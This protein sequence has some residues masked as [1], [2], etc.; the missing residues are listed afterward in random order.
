MFLPFHQ[1]IDYVPLLRLA[2]D[3]RLRQQQNGTTLWWT[4][5]CGGGADLVIDPTLWEN[6][7]TNWGRILL[8]DR[9]DNEGLFNEQISSLFGNNSVWAARLS[10]LITA[11]LIIVIL[12][13]LL[14]YGFVVI[15]R[16]SQYR[17]KAQNCKATK[18]GGGFAQ[19]IDQQLTKHAEEKRPLRSNEEESDDYGKTSQ[20]Q[21]NYMAKSHGITKNGAIRTN[22]GEKV[23]NGLQ[24]QQQREKISVLHE[25][26]NEQHN[27]E[28]NGGKAEHGQ[29]VGMGDERLDG[30]HEHNG[31]R[32]GTL[33][34]PKNDDCTFVATPL[35]QQRRRMPTTPSATTSNNNIYCSNLSAPPLA[36]MN[37][38]SFPPTND[39]QNGTYE[40]Q[41][42]PT[43]RV[44]MA[45]GA[46]A[47]SPDAADHSG[48]A[49]PLAWRQKQSQRQNDQPNRWPSAPIA[50]KDE[51]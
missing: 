48:D 10:L 40:R 49:K 14:L 18:N 41:K 37:N 31:G 33:P 11:A 38:T 36:P 24:Q 7:S 16:R 39:Q 51:L 21:Q 12:I 19:R 8:M 43:I 20:I 32:D 44:Q 30:S 25:H 9:S 34:A 47:S 28:G 22:G 17:C 26:V 6:N 45:N 35:L 3:A 42:P 1:R 27:N 15:K 4:G 29:N 23:G 46:N 2:A 5:K 50:P 13:A